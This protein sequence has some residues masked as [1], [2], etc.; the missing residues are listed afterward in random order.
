MRLL[1]SLVIFVLTSCA[2]GGSDGAPRGHQ[3]AL[4]GFT[5]NFDSS[6]NKWRQLLD[7]AREAGVT[8]LHIQAPPWAEVE[9]SPG[10]F[11]LSIFDSFFQML[12]EYNLDYSVDIATPLGISAVDVPSDFTFKSFDDPDLFTRYE[13]YV[14]A[15]LNR[16]SKATHV[17]LHTETAGSF[18]GSADE[19]DFQDYCELVSRTT[20][21]VRATL[22]G[23]GVGVYGTK[24]ESRE[25]LACL[26]KSTDFFG[27][28]YIADRGDD[29]HLALLTELAA[30]AGN[31]TLVINEAGIP[32]SPRIGGSEQAQVEFVGMMN[33]FARSLGDQLQFY[34][35]YLYI[36]DDESI[37]RQYVPAF[38]PNY[39][40]QQKEDLI[41]FFS[42]LGLHRADGTPK[43]AWAVF[44]SHIH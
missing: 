41:A 20:D 21:F 5:Q 4:A 31:K 24:N 10:V 8:S 17:I 3:V 35:Y 14:A 15:V 7:A 13:R 26:N 2:G 12:A 1:T 30:Q 27:I 43:P 32:T 23:V 19:K 40:E 9:L 42:S 44:K 25:I 28:S 22:P 37:V 34:S 16:F 29:D 36:D 38:F 39:S 11:D 18:F 6:E 33:E